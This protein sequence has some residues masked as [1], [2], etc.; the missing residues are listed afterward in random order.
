MT[1]EGFGVGH[2]GRGGVGVVGTREVPR[3]RRGSDSGPEGRGKKSDDGTV[4]QERSAPQTREALATDDRPVY[5][6][7][8]GGAGFGLNRRAPLL[9][10]W[11][12]G[13]P[14]AGEATDATAGPHPP[15]HG[16]GLARRPASATLRRRLP[17]AHAS[18]G[19]FRSPAS[20]VE[21]PTDIIDPGPTGRG[22][23][24]ARTP[25][26]LGPRRRRGRRRR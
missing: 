12:R 23:R 13:V 5:I 22:V 18:P 20:S 25:R 4:T 9:R 26:D 16:P 2:R 1:R 19:S 14:G 17:R 3:R 10:V 8:A 21:R 15:T 24:P 7:G 6:C 11:R